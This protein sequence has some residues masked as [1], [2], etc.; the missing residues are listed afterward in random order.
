MIELD[1]DCLRW[2]FILSIHVL[3]LI[4]CTE[5]ILTISL[6]TQPLFWRVDLVGNLSSNPHHEASWKT[7]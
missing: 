6:A 1:S 4:I 7:H 3:P 2:M 5:L